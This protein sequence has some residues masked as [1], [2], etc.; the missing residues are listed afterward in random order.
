MAVRPELSRTQILPADFSFYGNLSGQWANEPLVNLEQFELGGN[1][2]VRGYR[3][4]ELYS[5][6]GWV[7]QNEFRSPIYWRG[8]GSLKIGTQLTAFTDYGQGYNG[9]VP[10]RKPNS[11]SGVPAWGPTS[12]SALTWKATF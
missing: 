12:I 6:T 9:I 2:S 5:D 10:E 11:R 8:A 1:A 4:G 3:E 7:S